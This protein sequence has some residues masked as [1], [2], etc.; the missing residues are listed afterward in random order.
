MIRGESM[1]KNDRAEVI[2]LTAITLEYQAALQVNDGA[3][4]GRPWYS[5]ETSTGLPISFRKFKR[6]H[7]RDLNVAVTLVGEMGMLPAA[8]ALSPLVEEHQPRCIAMCGVCAGRRSKV[9]LG[10]VIAAERLFVHDGGKAIPGQTLQDLRTSNL[11]RPWKVA[12]ESID[13][14]SQF[15]EADWF[16]ARPVPYHWQEDWVLEQLHKGVED[17]TRLPEISVLCPQWSK[18]IKNLWET[19]ALE[20]GKLLLTEQGRERISR[21]MILNHNRLPDLSPIAEGSSR[22]KV[23]VAPMGSG[24]RVVEDED[25]WSFI[26]S[27]MRQT[28]AVEMEAAAIGGVIEGHRHLNLDGVVMKGVMDFADHGRDDHFKEFAARASAECLISFLREYAEPTTRD[29]VEVSTASSMAKEL[30]GKGDHEPANERAEMAAGAG[31]V[32]PLADVLLRRGLSGLTY[33]E[34]LTRIP[35]AVVDL[36]D[37]V[38][39]LRFSRRLGYAPDDQR[40]AQLLPEP[41]RGLSAALNDVLLFIVRNNIR[42]I[43]SSSALLRDMRSLLIWQ[44]EEIIDVLMSE[45]VAMSSPCDH[46]PT[47]I[48]LNRARAIDMLRNRLGEELRELLSVVAQVDFGPTLLREVAREYSIDL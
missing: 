46:A 4:D 5:T 30:S 40:R 37:A 45:G 1:S 7:G 27:H 41:K 18:V 26:T 10:D 16:K 44:V 36:E 3:V 43:E 42:S 11:K 21:V 31:G 8:T 20:D 35:E 28:L 34:L 22:F 17:P 32:L 29:P 47:A 12:L 14:A 24:N 23:H 38:D 19:G 6:A 33:E 39:A 9:N 48:A 15:A 13:F 25:V 2:V